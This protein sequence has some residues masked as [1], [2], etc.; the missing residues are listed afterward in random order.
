MLD[1]IKHFQ[2]F[3]DDRHILAFLANFGAFKDQIIDEDDRLDI[4]DEDGNEEIVNLPTNAIPKGMVTLE[5][6]FDSNPRIKES[7]A[8]D[9]DAG[10]YEQHNIGQEGQEKIVYIAK[11]CT[12]TKREKIIQ[13]LKEYIDVIAWGYEDLKNIWYIYY[14]TC[15]TFKNQ[16]E[17]IQEET[18][19]Y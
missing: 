4:V 1:N 12:P 15:Y 2:V 7:L 6:I 8:T 5:M 19:I 3:E 9:L 16:Y 10:E 14:H 18:M 11:I 13:I 17:A